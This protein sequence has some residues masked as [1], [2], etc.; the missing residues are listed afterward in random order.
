MFLKILT[1]NNMHDVR[2]SP[3]AVEWFKGIKREMDGLWAKGTFSKVKQT[4]GMRV[5]PTRFV[6]KIKTNEKGDVTKYK[7]RLVGKGFY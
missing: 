3:Q 5:I 7:A 6:F 2:A 1:P 4:P